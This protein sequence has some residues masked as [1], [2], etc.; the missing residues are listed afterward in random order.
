MTAD[1]EK[2]DAFFNNVVGVLRIKSD[3]YHFPRRAC[4]EGTCRRSGLSLGIQFYRKCNWESLLFRI[5]DFFNSAPDVTEAWKAR[6]LDVGVNPNDFHDILIGVF[7]GSA[8]GRT[9]IHDDYTS[10]TEAQRI[11]RIA[12]VAS[13]VFLGE[14]PYPL[15]EIP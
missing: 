12:N 15:E 5:V 11:T 2:L 6:V 1:D 3:D 14:N 8:R 13:K 7:I 10:A 9:P 4:F